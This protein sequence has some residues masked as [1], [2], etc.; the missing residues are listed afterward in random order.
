MRLCTGSRNRIFYWWPFTVSDADGWTV[1]GIWPTK[2]GEIGPLYCNHTSK[3]NPDLVEPLMSELEVHW[4]NVH[5]NSDRYGFWKHEW[6]KHGT[7]AAVLH[8]LDNEYKFF[9][10]GEFNHYVLHKDIPYTSMPINRSFHRFGLEHRVS[11]LRLLHRRRHLPWQAIQ[12]EG[13]VRRRSLPSAR[14]SPCHRMLVRPPWTPAS[15]PA[16]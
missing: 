7:C 9:K 11:D 16:S 4:T 8:P 12:R 10:Q 13:V 1:H 6:E 2:D 15:P 5:Q 3:F 14:R